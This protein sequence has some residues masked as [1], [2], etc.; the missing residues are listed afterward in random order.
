MVRFA[1]LLSLSALC[2]LA[3]PNL[4]L[5]NGR[6]W[7]GIASP[8]FAEAIAITGSKVSHVGTSGAITRMAGPATKVIDLKGRMAMPGFNDAHIHFLGG[9][10]GL[11][12]V[13]LTG[14]CTVEEMQRRIRDY[15]ERNPDVEWITGS[16]W[17]YS[18]FP[19]NRVAR[20]EDL[21]LAVK[22]RPAL[23]RAYDGHSSWANSKALRIGEVTRDTPFAGFGEIEK[24]AKT[25]E[26]TG[27]LKEGAT[28]LVSRHVPKPTHAAKLAALERGYK[29]LAQ[30]GITSIQ[31]ASGDLDEL[32]LYEELLRSGKMTARTSMVMST[33]GNKDA[34]FADW[35]LLKKKYAAGLLR[36][37]GVKF[38]LDGVIESH[39]AA[40]LE[41]YSDNPDSTGPMNWKPEDYK[42]AVARADRLGLQIYTHA[43][44]DRAV[45]TA[46]E[47]YEY[48]VQRNGPRFHLN[49]RDRR[50]R[51]EHIETIAPTDIPRFAVTNTMAVMQPIHADPGSVEVWSKA[52]GPV[53][54][55]LGFP[56]R[57]LHN[58]GARLVF[59]SDWPA[60]LT[61][62]PIRGLHN[63]VNRRTI[64]GRPEGGWNPEL[65]VSVETALR[66]YTLGGATASFEE[67]L[68]GT[69]EPGK[70][71]DI[72]VLSQDV[73]K[74][75]PMK[76]HES[77]VVMT[78]FDGR[79]IYESGS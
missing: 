47:A 48:A 66:A 70:L 32:A 44:G 50:F 10:L 30:L 52:V 13:D 40:L 27:F 73:T 76:I 56:W 58:A 43:I 26:P 37:L 12:E 14:A 68:K 45:R 38:M 24:D 3:Q 41:P 35:A 69:I 23:I 49:Q 5:T 62:D 74:I 34:P 79:V 36:V 1:L 25:G 39:T 22:D 77:R 72:V 2:L 31:N 46:L 33:G 61:L 55:K 11:R 65:R 28:S 6:I 21:D 8:R 71:A 59:S 20:K 9:S 53:R 67:R 64:D 57:A 29:L 7:T 17:E 60:C 18:C 15:A 16:G 42:E 75:D 78:V 19:A 4:I 51:I 54:A 63:A